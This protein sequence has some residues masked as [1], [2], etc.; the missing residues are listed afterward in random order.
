MMAAK[1]SL[2]TVEGGEGAGK[3]SLIP[4]LIAA[5][6][7]KGCPAMATREPGGTFLGEQ[8]RQLL[9]STSTLCP[10][11]ATAE[12]FL[13]LAGRSQHL[14]ESILPALQEGTFVICD[15]FNDST[16]AYQG[17]GRGLGTSYVEQLCSLACKGVV[18]ALTFLLDIDPTEGLARCSRSAG[19]LDRIEAESLAF[20][21]R[22][23]EALLERAAKDPSRYVIIDASAPLDDVADI[24]VK[25]LLEC[26][27]T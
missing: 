14:E 3:S 21:S 4:K 15:R 23:R 10:I 8:V 9:L 22:I 6:S 25:A 2:I 5:L 11:S 18:P 24:A 12:L 20:H 26:L 7:A 16:I 27:A 19:A 1:G 17:A 13:F